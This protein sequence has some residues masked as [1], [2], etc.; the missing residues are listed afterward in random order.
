VPP[1]SQTD[2]PPSPSEPAEEPIARVDPEPEPTPTDAAQPRPE[3][4]R[5]EGRD[6]GYGEGAAFERGSRFESSPPDIGAPHAADGRECVEWCPIC[7]TADV[8]RA[9]V[10]PEIRDQWHDVQREA[11]VTVRAL[12]DH[13]IERLERQPQ[14]AA[15]VEDI[16][17]Q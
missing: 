17:I 10:P 3:A 15:R 8:V 6:P 12:I 11:L 9:S 5:A 16:P 4:P 13:Y 7:R 1:P 2:A 14:T